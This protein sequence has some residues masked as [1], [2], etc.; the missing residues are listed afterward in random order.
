MTHGSL[1]SGFGG[2]DLAAEWM[3]W[4][5]FFHC[6]KDEFCQRILKYYWPNAELFKDIKESSFLKFRGTIDVLTGGFP[7]QPYSQS[8]KRKGKTD[9]RHLWPENYRAIK[10]IRPRW[11]VGEN[12]YGI[13]N[14]KKG[15]V[16]E[17]VQSD[18]ETEGYQ[19]W[20]YVLPAC[21]VNADHK[22]YRTWFIAHSNS[23]GLNGSNSKYE[24]NTS[25][26]G[27]HALC[28]INETPIS[29]FNFKRLEGQIGASWAKGFEPR[30]AVS[31]WSDWPSQSPFCNGDDGIPRQLDGITFPKWR[32]KSIQAAGNAIVPN[33]AYE[34]FKTIEQF[35][36]AKLFT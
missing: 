35:E 14:W 30:F 12:V 27:K 5:T 3:E 4:E 1:F 31:D 18:L 7:C 16:F 9:D 36:Q 19:V 15:L 29:N 28:N 23:N 10:E 32:K 22:R 13:I 33:L 24:V 6:E 34:I 2:F 17:E 8:G 26:D 21:S 11:Y 25:E 20:S